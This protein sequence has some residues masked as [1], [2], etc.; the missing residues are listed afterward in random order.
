LE[1]LDLRFG[2]GYVIIEAGLDLFGPLHL[3]LSLKQKREVCA[4]FSK[5]NE[6]KS[7]SSEPLIGFLAFVVSTLRTKNYEINNESLRE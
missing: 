6:Q 3:A 4:S 5:K 7:T 2:V 1:V